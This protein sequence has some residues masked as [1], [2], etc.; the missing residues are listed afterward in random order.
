MGAWYDRE[1][2]GYTPPEVHA[3]K[4]EIADAIIEKI[5][6]DGLTAAQLAKDYPTIRACHIHRLMEGQLPGLNQI[7]F[8]ARAAGVKVRKAVVLEAA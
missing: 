3:W 8:I 5:K 4:N 7:I 2:R 1:Y 6:K